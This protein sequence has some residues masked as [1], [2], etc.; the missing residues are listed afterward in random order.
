M[1][2]GE[3]AIGAPAR[4]LRRVLG[5]CAVAGVL[6][7][8]G[9]AARQPPAAPGPQSPG[10]IF[11]VR[12]FGALGDGRNLDTA[13]INRAIEAAAAA[14]GGTVRFPAGTYL[15]V[16]IHLKS[17]VGLHLDRGATIEAA[18]PGVAAYDEPEPNPWGDARKY[19]DFGHSH[20]H[21]ALIWGED[22]HDVA[23]GGPGLIDGAA[24]VTNNR[25]PRGAGDKSISLNNFRNVVLRD[26]TILRG[27]WFAILAT[28]VDNL[29]IENLT[30]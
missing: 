20:W 10:D 24:L 27:G 15:S 29:A 14:G 5:A 23:I 30:I 26:L 9:A 28:G 2:G 17:N 1:P 13:A 8:G 3:R 22:L 7:T 12:S 18:A 19:Q 16:S 11:D 21:N 4:A 6:A 25:G